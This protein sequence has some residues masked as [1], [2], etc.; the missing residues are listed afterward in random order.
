MFQIPASV[1]P[2]PP[3]DQWLILTGQEPD[4]Y[5]CPN[6]DR[7]PARP[8]EAPP[9]YCRP[10]VCGCPMP[11]PCSTCTNIVQPVKVGRHWDRPAAHCEA[12]AKGRHRAQTRETIERII[13][14]QLRQSAKALY[15]NPH[16][17]DLMA[18]L[19]RWIGTDKLGIS[20][21][22]SCL[23]VHG[24]RGSGKSVAAAWAIAKSIND[25][26]V[27]NALY[28]T[29]D[30]FIRA[31]VDQFSDAKDVANDSRSLMYRAAAIPFLVLDELGST[32]S[33]GYSDREKKETI[34]LLHKRLSERLPTMIVTNLA[35]S[36]LDAEG[37]LSHLGWL[38]ERIDSRFQ[39]CGVA[40]R[41]SG[42]DMRIGGAS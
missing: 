2:T 35:P 19:Y 42:P 36:Q 32:R 34:R 33:H 7:G 22:P 25:E 3:R 16:R 18:A 10:D 26:V 27:S 20:G 24:S 11:W 31:A 30:T 41:C 38:D 15:K 8:T 29:E 21:G 40:V 17:A 12:C 37:R 9:I 14:D 5:L 6:C 13:P 28:L 4:E 1:K 39:G 23:L